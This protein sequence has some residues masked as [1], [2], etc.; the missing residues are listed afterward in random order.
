[1]FDRALA[2]RTTSPSAFGGWRIAQKVDRALHRSM[3]KHSAKPHFVS[4]AFSDS[5][6]VSS[7]L[8]ASSFGFR[9]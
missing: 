3:L 6:P 4:F 1:M 9:H 2:A 7:F 5:A 8:R